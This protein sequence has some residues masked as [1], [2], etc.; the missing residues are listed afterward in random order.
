MSSPFFPRCSP[1]PWAEFLICSQLCRPQGEIRGSLYES[2]ESL[3]AGPLKSCFLDHVFGQDDLLCPSI[4][5][6]KGQPPARLT[7]V[8]QSSA[9]WSI[10]LSDRN[11]QDIFKKLECTFLIKN[12]FNKNKYIKNLLIYEII[13][14]SLS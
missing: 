3:P 14:K 11:T 9:E 8:I 6:S 13:I 1:G 2:C 10:T 5:S 7:E 12:M 4:Q